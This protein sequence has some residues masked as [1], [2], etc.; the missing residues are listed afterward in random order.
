MLVIVTLCV[1]CRLVRSVSVQESISRRPV[2]P[3]DLLYTDNSVRRALDPHF[4]PKRIEL[5]FQRLHTASTINML[6]QADTF[7]TAHAYT[8]SRYLLFLSS[9]GHTRL[10]WWDWK[11]ILSNTYIIFSGC[12]LDWCWLVWVLSRQNIIMLTGT[13]HNWSIS[14]VPEFNLK[15]KAGL[16][17]VLIDP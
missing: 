17:S 14:Q 12:T 5:K 9:L 10:A 8:R 16:Q 15:A 13:L 3:Q 6:G 4:S 2:S 1:L 7:H 11:S